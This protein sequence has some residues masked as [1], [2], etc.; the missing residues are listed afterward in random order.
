MN[1]IKTRIADLKV[2]DIVAEHG[3]TFRVLFDPVP[4][5]GH[6]D[7]HWN[8]RECI[9]EL[10]DGPVN[11]AYTSAECLTGEVPGYFKPG[12]QWTFQGTT[13]VTVNRVGA[14]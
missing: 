6:R 2:G 12:S 11:C 3:G 9:H 4:S 14:A 5:E 13:A 7:R 10:H 8:T 1:T